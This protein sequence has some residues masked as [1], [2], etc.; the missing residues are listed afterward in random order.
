MFLFLVRGGESPS[1]EQL[2]LFALTRCCFSALIHG[3][4]GSAT[5]AKVMT[6]FVSALCSR[7]LSTDGDGVHLASS[8]SLLHCHWR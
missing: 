7:Y 2:A 4:I 1:F 5:I 8:S 6:G 3:A